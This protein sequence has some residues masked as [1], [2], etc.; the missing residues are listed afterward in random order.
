MD[1]PHRAP[2][3]LSHHFS[4]SV[5]SRKQSSIKDFYKFFSIPGIGNLAGGLPHQSFFPYDTLEAATALPQRFTPTPD[6]AGASAAT[7][8]T[9][10]R[11]LVPKVSPTEDALRKIDL[12]TALQYGTAQGYPPLF[13]FLHAFTRDNLHPDVPYAGGPDIIL[14]CGNT[15]GFDKALQVFSDEWSA[16]K[17]W[18]RD[19]QGILVEEFA[20]MNAIQAAAPRGLQIVP[21]AMDGE[22]MRDRGPGGLRDVLE[23]WDQ[24]K[25]RRPHLMYTV[26]LGQNPTSGTLSTERRAALYRLCQEHD[27]VIVEDEP[28][29]YLQ[30]PSAAASEEARAEGAHLHGATPGH[31]AP[32]KSSGY[33]FLD[34][35]EPSYLSIDTDGR[36]VRL[37]TF[38]KTFAPGCRV[39]WITAQPAVV[40]RV[41][42][43]TEVSTQQPSGFAQS[44]IAEILMGP[45]TG[46]DTGRGGD[47]D[48]SG[49]GVAGYVRWL[50]GLRGEYERRMQTMCSI[51]EDGRYTM[52]SSPGGAE[53]ANGNGSGADAMTAWSVVDKVQMYD[54]VW[55]RA[56]MF[57]WV[58]LKLAT[59]PL[60]GTLDRQKLSHALWLHLTTKPYLVLVAPALIFCPTDEVREARGPDFFRLCFAAVEED[61]VRSTSHRFVAAFNSFWAKKD[62]REIEEKVQAAA[63]EGCT[64]M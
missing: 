52:R 14:T 15:D 44:M 35:L 13:S 34:S 18:V 42:R 11:T 63:A 25:G 51:L 29:W 12:S 57:V 56:G 16:E 40:E 48:G 20:Y 32:R 10:T 9:P 5:R 8:P 54:F 19:R 59:H 28:Y 45:A 46:D 22:G 36:V 4:R 49:W 50:A 61:E 6:H 27:V 64:Q 39:G 30:Y 55:P 41:L 23:N 2:L 37:D 38:S 58:E 60:A 24:S 33:P 1:P 21:V 43:I 47:R 3:D 31:V 26:T 62:A 53:A 17:D 7:D